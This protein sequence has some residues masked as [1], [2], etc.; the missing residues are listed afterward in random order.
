MKEFYAVS[1]YKRLLGVRWLILA[2]EKKNIDLMSSVK[3]K[4]CPVCGQSFRNVF[5]LQRHI[6]TTQCGVALE[7]MLRE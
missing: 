6:D 2:A 5:F 1:K 4:K 3:E 7:K